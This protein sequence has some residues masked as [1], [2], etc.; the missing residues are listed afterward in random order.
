MD[1]LQGRVCA[2]IERRAGE[3]TEFAEAVAARPELGFFEVE[4]AGWFSRAL[5]GMGLPHETGL[6][7]TGVRAVLDGGAPG[8]TVAVL[9]ELDALPVRGHPQAD[10]ATGAAHACGHNAQLAMVLG[11]AHG[12]VDSGA[13]GRLAGRVVLMAVPAEEYVELER[14]LTLRDEG[15]IEFLSG[16]AEMLRAGAFDDVDLAMMVHTTSQERDRSIAV[17]GSNNGV[18]AKLVRFVGRASHAGSSPHQGI[19]ALNAAHV[20]LA[21]MHA[22][23]ETYR[24][25]DH[26]RVH[27][28]ITRGGDVVNAVPDDVRLEMFVRGATREAIADASAKVDRALRAGALAIGARVAVTT[29]PGYL[30]MRHDPTLVRLFRANAERLVGPDEVADAGHR[31]GSTDMGDLSHVMPVVHPYAGGATGQG[32]GADYTIAD[33]ERA[34]LNPARALAMTVVD[35]LADDGSAAREVV[36]TAE[37]PLTRAG[38]LAFIRELQRTWEYEEEGG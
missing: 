11:V 23:R 13:L 15:K 36:A 38:Y 20:A 33:P 28:I 32:H 1:D 3:L 27:P 8:P 25:E 7:L 12:L 10:P 4:T 9:G 31:G 22:Q 6:A 14:R 24:D 18:A 2:A 29:L 34:I 19:N 16:K 37:P 30:P 26:V 35:L 5:Q 21:A 17:G